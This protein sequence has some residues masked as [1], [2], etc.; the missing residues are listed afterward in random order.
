MLLD[1]AEVAAAGYDNSLD[2]SAELA[3]LVYAI[4]ALLRDPA[5]VVAETLSIAN[6]QSAL[7]DLEGVEA[8]STARSGELDKAVLHFGTH[9]S[10]AALQS[11]HPADLLELPDRSI[12]FV[13]DQ[14][15]LEIYGAP[16]NGVARQWIKAS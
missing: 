12:A 11:A 7:V 15:T 1:D 3:P 4:V 14:T 9:V 16:D 5:R 10:L 13:W 6:I 8:F 2:L